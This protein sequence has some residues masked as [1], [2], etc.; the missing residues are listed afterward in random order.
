MKTQA[1]L[2]ETNYISNKLYEK[3]KQNYINA[4]NAINPVFIHIPGSER[5]LEADRS[6]SERSGAPQTE[7]HGSGLPVVNQT[8]PTR[9]CGRRGFKRGESNGI[10]RNQTVL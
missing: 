6:G 9:G 7:R 4:I 10:K 8:V 1:K 2:Y 3:N 5:I